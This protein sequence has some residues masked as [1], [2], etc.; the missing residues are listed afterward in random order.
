MKSSEQCSAAM[1]YIVVY[2]FLSEIPENPYTSLVKMIADIL[3]RNHSV[4]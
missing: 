4:K 1:K 3:I 2:P